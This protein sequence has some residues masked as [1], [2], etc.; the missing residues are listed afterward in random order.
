MKALLRAVAAVLVGGCAG[1]GGDLKPARDS[2]QGAAYDDVVKRWGAPARGTT[3]TDGA[4]VHSWVSEAY[5]RRSG[6]AIGVG[7]FGGGGS[8]GGGVGASF[9][10]GGGG[11]DA[12]RCER[13]LTFRDGKVT[14]QDWTG[15]LEYCNTFGR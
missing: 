5:T 13:T 11:G 12:V 10:F 8:V 7:I 15:P 14:D 3:L 2:W 9:P 4:Q 6:P 1:M